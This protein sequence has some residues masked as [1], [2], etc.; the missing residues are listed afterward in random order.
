MIVLVSLYEEE[1][2]EISCSFS[3]QKHIKKGPCEN[4]VSKQLS[5]GQEKRSHKKSD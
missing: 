1:E 2:R 5:T 4:L 3:L